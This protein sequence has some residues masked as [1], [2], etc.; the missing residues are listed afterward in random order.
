MN[1]A[2]DQFVRLFYEQ[3]A[4]DWKWFE[5]ALRM[6]NINCYSR[7]IEHSRSTLE[8]RIEQILYH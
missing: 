8:T 1:D 5:E 3:T 7:V 2:H 6:E 4:L